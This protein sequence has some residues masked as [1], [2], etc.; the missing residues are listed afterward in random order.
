MIDP[1]A[2]DDLTMSL[3][4][5]AQP[6][7]ELEVVA[8]M[9]A[10]VSVRAYEGAIE[11]LT[12]ADS[13]AVGI[14][15]LREGR[16]GFA[17]AGSLDLDVALETLADARDNLGFAEADPHA[18]LATADGVAA[19]ELPGLW[20]DAVAAMSIEEKMAL[21]V[22]LERRTRSLDPRVYGVRSATYSDRQSMSVLVSSTGLRAEERSTMSSLGVSALS[23]DGAS[24]QTGF[25]ASARRDP[26]ELDPGEV[27]A[28]AV[29]KATRLLGATKPRS[30][31]VMLVL[32]PQVGA[33]IISIV[34][35]MLSG[36]RVLKGRTPFA[37]RLGEKI[38]DPRLTL[39]D[40]P[41]LADSFGA[42]AF[43]GEGLATRRNVLI[44]DGHL[45]GFL[46]DT[47]SGGRAGRGSTASAVRSTRSTPAVGWQALQVRP[48]E[49]DLDSIV[50]AVDHGLL[51]QSMSG[52]HSGVNAV[53]GDFSVGVD[54]LMIRNGVL[55]EPIREATI[56]STLPRMLDE[57]VHVGAD[58]DHRPSGVSVPTI[59]VAGVSL[60]GR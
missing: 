17:S 58:L 22:E 43:D 32:E 57:I 1:R 38:G 6:G 10:R 59:S 31:R 49:G 52:M 20:S 12:V 9:S 45:Q 18:R 42:G 39:V 24:R 60:S 28:E 25:G 41:T 30:G 16:M 29:A 44:A 53:S 34:G 5:R 35:A 11:N 51:V 56:A 4:E 33:S 36:D 50:A 2:L 54:G 14:R 21:A 26:T 13:A 15:V 27:A 3:L 19:G 55:A 7:E 46:Y 47:I 37:G 48:G 8:A 40:D 23:S